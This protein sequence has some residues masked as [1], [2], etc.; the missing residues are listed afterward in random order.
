MCSLVNAI[1]CLGAERSRE[2]SGKGEMSGK[3]ELVNRL[4]GKANR[5][6]AS[7]LALQIHRAY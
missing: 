6:I 2:E 3:Y 5:S 1:A 4:R 7:N